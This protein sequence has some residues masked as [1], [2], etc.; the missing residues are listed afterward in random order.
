MAIIGRMGG[1]KL[2]NR[3]P[4]LVSLQFCAALGFAVAGGSAIIYALE[5]SVKAYD[6]PVHPPHYPWTHKPLLHA[7][8]HASLEYVPFRRLIDVA[9]S[10]EEMKQ[11][12]SEYQ[13]QDGPNE[14]GE[15]FMRP[16][17]ISD[18]F[19]SPYPNEDAAAYANNGAAPPDLSLIVLGREGNEDYIL[20]LLSGYV[21]PDDVPAGIEVPEGGHYN[22]YFLGSVIA[23]APPL[24]NNIIEYEDGTPATRTQLAKDVIT[25]LTW[26]GQPEYDKR[27]LWAIKAN[28]Y[29]ALFLGFLTYINRHKWTS[30]RSRI[31]MYNELAKKK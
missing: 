24:Y 14:Y 28:L 8:D 7:L 26:C 13:I 20:S 18:Y 12:A 9:Y 5:Q 29:F 19:P 1:I 22:P 2:L 21:E 17:K 23:M 10:E 25:F 15:F 16:G 6:W 3:N 27:Q 4:P 11:I 31:V 30:L